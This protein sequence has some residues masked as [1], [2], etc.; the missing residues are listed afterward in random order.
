MNRTADTS[1]W[2]I[3]RY[4]R[5]PYVSVMPS[6]SFS[7]P[8][9]FFLN[10]SVVSILFKNPKTELVAVQRENDPRKWKP[11]IRGKP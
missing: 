9:I 6:T 7:V 11:P 2:A 8:Y 1:D 5:L 3:L 10:V 4:N